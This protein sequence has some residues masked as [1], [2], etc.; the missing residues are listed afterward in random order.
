V[1]AAGAGISLFVYGTLVLPEVMEAVAGRAFPSRPAELPGF[2]RFRLRDRVFPGI[3]P[4][5]GATTSGLLCDGIG[6]AALE[7][8]DEFEG[9]LYERLRLQVRLSGGAAEPAH[10]YVIRPEHREL[11]TPEPWDPQHFTERHLSGYLAACRRHRATRRPAGER[12]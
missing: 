3:A 4:R 10:V 5:P 2:A 8:L 1:S 9:D 7:L 11:L 12:A 6:C